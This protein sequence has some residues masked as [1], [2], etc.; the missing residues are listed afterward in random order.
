MKRESARSPK[1]SVS[2]RT[3]GASSCRGP[4]RPPSIA[5]LVAP[6]SLVAAMPP[7]RNLL[8]MRHQPGRRTT[9]KRARSPERPKALAARR[10]PSDKVG[11]RPVTIGHASGVSWGDFARFVDYTR[12]MTTFLPGSL[13]PTLAVLATVAEVTLGTALLLGI[14]LRLCPRCGAPARHLRNVDD[15]PAT[16]SR[17]VSLQR[18][19]PQCRH[20]GSRNRSPF[21]PYPSTRLEQGLAAQDHPADQAERT[22]GSHPPVE[23]CAFGGPTPAR[24]NLRLSAA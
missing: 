10:S 4:R 16:T 20:A 17:T 11:D 14:P 2:G 6:F 24:L 12:S 15:D 19:R 7:S 3:A 1:R 9:S 22:G 23:G 21:T 5:N 8:C 13:A 18:L